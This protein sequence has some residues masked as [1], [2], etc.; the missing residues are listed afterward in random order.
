MTTGEDGITRR[1]AS[2][3]GRKGR[4]GSINTGGGSRGASVTGADGRSRS[5]ARSGGATTFTGKAGNTKTVAKGK[6]KSVQSKLNTRRKSSPRP[7]R[8]QG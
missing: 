2:A 4:S 7:A 6:G 1:T 3:T 5:I 8:K